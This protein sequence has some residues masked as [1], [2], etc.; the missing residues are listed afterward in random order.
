MAFQ[1]ITLQDDPQQALDKINQHIHDGQVGAAIPT[2]GL[3]DNA[4]TQAKL[5]DQAVSTVKIADA[6]I[7]NQ[8]ILGGTITA[9]RLAPGVLAANSITAASMGWQN[10]VASGMDVYQNSGSALNLT[11]DAGRVN[12]NDAFYDHV[13]ETVTAVSNSSGLAYV[14]KDPDQSLTAGIQPFCWPSVDAK[15]LFHV[16]F[17]DATINIVDKGPQ[18]LQLAPDGTVANVQRVP[19]WLGYAR[20]TDPTCGLKTTTANF[21][22]WTAGQKRTIIYAGQWRKGSAGDCMPMTVSLGSSM[23][24]FRINPTSGILAFYQSQYSSSDFDIG[25]RLRDGQNYMVAWDWDGYYMRAFFNGKLVYKIEWLNT[26]GV[27]SGVGNVFIGEYSNSGYRSHL[28][29]YFAQLR[30]DTLTEAQHAALANKAGFPCEYVDY[31]AVAPTL[32]EG[33]AESHV[34]TMDEAAGNSVGDTGT[35]TTPLTGT[36]NNAPIIIS[37][38]GAGYGRRFQGVATSNISLGNYKFPDTWGIFGYMDSRGGAAAYRALM[39]NYNGTNGNQIYVSYGG[40]RCLTVWSAPSGTKNGTRTMPDQG[41]C[42][43]GLVA[44]DG[45]VYLYADSPEPEF[46]PNWVP[47]TTNNNPLVIG[48]LGQGTYPF[49]GDLYH[50][51]MV[52]RKPTAEEIRKWYHS[53]KNRG[54]RNI[55]SDVLPPNSLALGLVQTDAVQIIKTDKKPRWGRKSNPFVDRGRYMTDWVWATTGGAVRTLENPLGHTRCKATVL[56][57]RNIWDPVA[58]T[59]DTIYSDASGLYGA[60]IDRMDNNTITL[61]LGGASLN[62]FGQTGSANVNSTVGWLAVLLEVLPDDMVQSTDTRM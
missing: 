20:K 46:I 55:A 43:F 19:G 17:N 61:A 5:A 36:A 59:V 33:V 51:F 29:H 62:D 49:D 21:A 22:G 4:V 11:M 12:I 15:T 23:F 8:K 58:L 44:A 24:Y 26:A 30:N 42:F 50:L 6:A 45:G 40:D 35:G 37:P 13:P 53:F 52:T 10:F 41:P 56:Y 57:K 18:A 27:A 3:A 60:W 31:Q 38:Y 25:V 16:D 39:G 34:W 47:D 7:T 32:A 54:Y 1:P 9:D 2:S 14:K 28:T 48:N